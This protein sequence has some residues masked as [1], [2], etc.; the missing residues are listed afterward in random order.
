M[1]KSNLMEEGRTEAVNDANAGL[2]N[3]RT[4][5]PTATL[6]PGSILATFTSLCSAQKTARLSVS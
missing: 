5:S 2:Q 3:C 1:N 6:A 4:N